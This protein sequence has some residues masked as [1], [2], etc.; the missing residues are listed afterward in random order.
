MGSPLAPPRDP[1]IEEAVESA[2]LELSFARGCYLPDAPDLTVKA[3]EV[4]DTPVLERM[5]ASSKRV[6]QALAR[7]EQTGGE[8]VSVSRWGGRKQGA[9]TWCVE[10]MDELRVGDGTGWVA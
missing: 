8:R 2:L 10:L 9:T 6:G 4:A 5:G 7:L 1:T 3:R